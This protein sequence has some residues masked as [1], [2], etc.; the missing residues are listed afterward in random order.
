LK[1]PPCSLIDLKPETDNPSSVNVPV[2]SKTIIETLP[3]TLILGGSMQKIFLFLSYR[4]AKITPEVI[5]AGRAGGIAIVIRSM[6]LLKVDQASRYVKD[7]FKFAS[8]PI[9]ATSPRAQAK[10]KESR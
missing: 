5:A 6:N 8:I 1:F 9:K 4:T 3:A 7:A 2:L 10:S